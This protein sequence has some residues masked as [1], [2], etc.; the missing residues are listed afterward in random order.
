MMEGELAVIETI[1]MDDMDFFEIVN[2]FFHRERAEKEARLRKIYESFTPLKIK[3]RRKSISKIL[4][5]MKKRQQIATTHLPCNVES[6][7]GAIEEQ[8]K[9]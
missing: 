7:S 8:Q 3:R 2:H 5:N 1:R 9:L 6:S 4:S